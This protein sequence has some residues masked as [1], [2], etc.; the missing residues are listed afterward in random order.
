MAVKR[1]QAAFL[2][3]THAVKCSWLRKSSPSSFFCILLSLCIASAR[4]VAAANEEAVQCS[5]AEAC[6]QDAAR[7]FRER[8]S[9][10]AISL[11][12]K[13]LRTYPETP[14]EGRAALLLGRHYQ[15][16]SDPQALAHLLAVT[17][18]L[19]LLGDYAQ[20]YLGGALAA[21]RDLNG[22][23]TAYDM[24]AVQY[25]DS[26]LRP[27]ALYRSAEAWYQS[28]D[29][30]RA[31]ERYARFLA[32]YARHALVPAVLLRQGD[33]QLK[34]GDAAAQHT[35][36]QI[37]T[38][39]AASP[40]ADEAASRL[41]RLRDSGVALP[42][43]TPQDWSVRAKTLFEAG[44]YARAIGAFEELL[45]FNQGIPDP[46]QAKL[47]L[48]IARVRMKQYE[49]AQR[50]FGELAHSRKGALSQEAVLWQARVLLRLGKDDLLLAL[51]REVE[52]GLLT[53]DLKGRFLLL[54]ASQ[55]VDRGRFD[56]ALAA[57][58]EAEEGAGFALAA[59]SSWQAGW[60]HYKL[61]HYEEAVRAFERSVRVQGE[62]PYAVPSLYWK[63]RSLEKMGQTQKARAAF[64]AVCA[65]FP[66][67]YYCHS[68][69]SRGEL[70][71]VARQND[72]TDILEFSPGEPQDAGLL[73]DI[74]Y[75]R[76]MELRAIGWLREAAEEL[77]TLTSQVARDRR[78]SLWLARLLYETAEYHRALSLIRLSFS[79]VLDR[80]GGG[81]PTAFW[82]LAYP[83][84]YFSAVKN[85]QGGPG[86]DPH[87]VMAVIREESAYN[88]VALSSA[89][90]M[91]LMQLMPST[92]QQVAAQL[93]LEPYSRERLFDPCFNIRLGSQYLNYLGEKFR[94]NLVYTLAAYNAGPDIVLKWEQQ[95]G[96]AEADEFIESIPYT[97]TRQYVK[98][99]LRSYQEYKRIFHDAKDDLLDKP[100]G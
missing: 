69:R 82:K 66:N 64:Q 73:E 67:S 100:C 80:G 37:W 91:G 16:Q 20:Y 47:Q 13:I 74:H 81:V 58:Q 89:G 68:G 18:T 15:E 54:L 90:A 51:A 49:E 38:Q 21:R 60:L 63:A 72:G 43:F 84:G 65:D 42:E 77:G 31:T 44:Q 14:W 50:V 10:V 6:L 83:D 5:S 17:R 35:F 93:G 2:Q 24:L 40:Q 19:P 55:H 25:P 70:A 1:G 62:G 34:N 94:R 87:L 97:E 33:C 52:A 23:A 95:F 26:L 78:S 30:R 46:Q 7:A 41:Q 96:G 27:Q 29:C 53:G 92:G 8:H 79:D 39:Y 12:Q 22:A 61:G 4:L 48:G 71:G 45:K 86:V 9:D 11:L 76:A 3:P 59:E 36:R 75:R 85:L 56:R 32:E 28:D 57:Y 88:P 98:K 99:V